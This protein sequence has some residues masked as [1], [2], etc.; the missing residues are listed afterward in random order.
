MGGKWLEFAFYFA[1]SLRLG[2]IKRNEWNWPWLDLSVDFDD[3][4]RDGLQMVSKD[5]E[6][7]WS[8]KNT[9]GLVC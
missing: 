2:D 7:I 9:S 8:G 4:R 6:Q 5:R 3:H 1:F